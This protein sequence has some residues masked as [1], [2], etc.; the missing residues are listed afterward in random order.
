[1]GK[2]RG[3]KM[4]KVS[5]RFVKALGYHYPDGWEVYWTVSGAGH[6]WYEC[7]VSARTEAKWINNWF[8]KLEARNAD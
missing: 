4:D 7:E 5:V 1:V 6:S 8:K 3:G 2:V